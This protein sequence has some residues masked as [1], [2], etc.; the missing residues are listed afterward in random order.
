MATNY[1]E[2]LADSTGNPEAEGHDRGVSATRVDYA[3]WL[4]L[5]AVTGLECV[6][7]LRQAG[8]VIV[9]NVA[10]CVELVRDD[11]VRLEVPLSTLLSPD[12]LLAILQ[13]AG[14]S[15]TRFRGLLED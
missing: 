11:G 2:N 14:I 15:P 5:P 10:R 6:R 13:R 7:A 1:P 12:V 9:A 3:T 8:F 4:K